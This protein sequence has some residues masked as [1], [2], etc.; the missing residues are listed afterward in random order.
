M[1][2]KTTSNRPPEEMH[3]NQVRLYAA[4]AEAMGFEPVRLAIHDLDADGGG[5]QPVPQDDAAR[6][7]L[8]ERLEAWAE[9]IRSGR[10]LPPET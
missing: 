1:H 6:E 7:A 10:E 9:G 2:F 8:R 5:R 4:A 3:V